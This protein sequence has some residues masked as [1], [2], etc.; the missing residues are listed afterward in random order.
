MNKQFLKGREYMKY[1][2]RNTVIISL[3]VVAGLLTGEI[4][5]DAAT[6]DVS[7]TQ[8]NGPGSLRAAITTA[9]TNGQ[10]DVI[11]IPAG[12]YLLNGS[13]GDD[14]NS[15]GDLDIDT[16]HSI[17]INGAGTQTTTIDGNESDRIF[18]IIKGT[19]TISGLTIH[20]GK[21]PDGTL[22][23][24]D[25]AG[26]GGILNNGNL[27]ITDCLIKNNETGNGHNGYIDYQVYTDSGSSGDGGGIHNSGTLTMSNC[28]VGNNFTGDNYG[29][30]LGYKL[31]RTGN[32]GG[33][34]N[35]GTMTLNA[36]TIQN[37]LTGSTS[38]SNEN[39]LKTGGCG[40]GVYNSGTQHLTQCTIIH[41]TTGNRNGPKGG[42]GGGVFNTGTDESSLTDCIIRNNNLSTTNSSNNGDGGG[43]CNCGIL[44]LTGCDISSNSTHSPD[45]YGYYGNGGGVCNSN[46]Y[47]ENAAITMINCSI[48]ENEA[49]NGYYETLAGSGGGLYNNCSALLFN[50][51]ISHNSCGN[52]RSDTSAGRGGGI[53][54]CEENF[55]SSITLIACTIAYNF[56]PIPSYSSYYIG[57]G[58][59]IYSD[60]GTVMIK[61][62][63][64]ANNS[65]GETGE[66][67]DCRGT[68]V[69]GGYNLIKDISGCTLTG[70]TTGNIIGSDP[71]LG[72][73]NYN[74]GNT[75][76][77]ALLTGSPAIDAG[78]A[79]DLTTDQRG[80]VRPQDLPGTTNAIDG[81]DIGAYEFVNFSTPTSA[82]HLS[83]NE[84]YLGCDTAG[85]TSPPQ[86]LQITNTGGGTLNWTATAATAPWLIISPDTGTGGATVTFSI[87]PSGLTVG[88]ISAPVTVS[89]YNADNSPQTVN[90]ILNVF[91]H[92]LSSPA[93][94]SFDTPET[95]ST[96]A[97]SIAVTGWAVDD[98]GVASVK[99]Y[100]NAVE[101]EGNSLIYIGE[102]TMVEGARPDVHAAYPDMPGSNSAGWGYMMLTNFLPNQGNGTFT[103]HAV[104]NDIEGN[105]TTLGTKTIRCDNTNAVNP[106]GA[107]D[108]PA[109]GGTAS[110]KKFINYGWALTPLPNAI[111]T[112]GSTIDVWIDGV[113]IGNPVY[114]QYR[115]DIAAFF[116]GYINSNGAV[117]YFYIDTSTY[118]NGTHTIQW[119]VTD[120]NQNT[121]GI[122]SRFFT[123]NNI[124]R[125]AG[126][127]RRLSEGQRAAPF[128]I[129][130]SLRESRRQ[131]LE[132]SADVSTPLLFRKGF[133]K[134]C[135]FV[136]TFAGDNGRIE[137]V[138]EPVERLEIR[139]WPGRNFEKN[140]GFRFEGYS[141]NMGRTGPLP[142]G[143]TLD[144]KNGV[145]YWMPGPGF[146]GTFHM[147]FVRIDLSGNAVKRIIDVRIN[148][149][150]VSGNSSGENNDS[151]T[152]EN[153]Q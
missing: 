68:I 21:T 69:S 18:H 88:I 98:I 77:H 83:R 39:T 70:S 34:F 42:S 49:A 134:T 139:L 5:I 11:N 132:I 72:S 87:N 22:E 35:S 48:T 58:C 153:I 112:D 82:L 103:L 115:S 143:S 66:T 74:G 152:W 60:G 29:G 129:P 79:F 3:L 99:I 141:M 38:A 138:I 149:S 151:F 122:G 2:I 13:A 125:S 102:A 85:N 106:F 15:G 19:V 118:D 20:K 76:C 37:N 105:A 40:G 32:G 25:S 131:P 91:Q 121:D 26:G 52:G 128:G 61:N 65:L 97:G 59:G 45:D 147:E 113:S 56:S 142:V 64:I 84:I 28:T 94:G 31:G 86:T 53:Y 109:Q 101:G 73:L 16:L 71:V 23:I 124:L 4:Q 30:F 120:N 81:T 111:P 136:Q 41:N 144:S 95:G 117:G 80:V 1:I 110:G 150:E 27:T 62:T 145:F 33:I 93:I 54:N 10:D 46:I 137:I 6:I 8:D 107:I 50:C 57:S 47:H 24:L 43:V 100:R 9:N 63:I 130:V 114:N 135:E 78:Y 92:N 140:D 51:T 127:L 133:G 55:P 14:D 75:L 123:V 119:T 116:P 67:P 17:T 44:S 90:I 108:T 146:A 89:A 36:V 7:T 104:V 96:V 148:T 12:I 126:G